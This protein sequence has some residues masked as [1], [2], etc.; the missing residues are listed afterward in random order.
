MKI[1]KIVLKNNTINLM[2]QWCSHGGE[3]LGSPIKKQLVLQLWG[4]QFA[5]SLNAAPLGFASAS[6]SRH[7]FLGAAPSK[8][9]S[10]AGV[11]GHGHFCPA[12][13]LGWAN[14]HLDWSTPCHLQHSPRLSS[15]FCLLL[16]IFLQMWDVYFAW[17]MM[18]CLPLSFT[19]VTPKKI[20]ALHL[21]LS[22]CVCTCHS[23]ATT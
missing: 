15:Q 23:S 19:W 16:P 12:E 3:L 17:L 4:E 21:S 13:T 1:S 6:M 10:T 9:V 20:F 8:R 22:V 14:T 11:Q 2:H 18:L 5:E 7:T